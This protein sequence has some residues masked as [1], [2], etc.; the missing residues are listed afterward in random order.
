[1]EAT[2]AWG[3]SPLLSERD[4]EEAEAWT[5]HLLCCAPKGT[6][7]CCFK[8]PNLP[9]LAPSLREASARVALLLERLVAPAGMQANLTPCK[10][11]ESPHLNA[12]SIAPTLCIGAEQVSGT[13]KEEGSASSSFA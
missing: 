5:P 7:A 4:E 10:R 3:D 2:D 8:H 1:M 13:E 11:L 9:R 12:R 6:E